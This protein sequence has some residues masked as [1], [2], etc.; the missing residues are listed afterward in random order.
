MRIYKEKTFADISKE[1]AIKAFKERISKTPFDISNTF[2][3][4]SK[5]TSKPVF[6]SCALCNHPTDIFPANHDPK[7]VKPKQLCIECEGIER[8]GY[9]VDISDMIK[10]V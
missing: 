7:I 5:H 10:E 1:K 6:Y 2:S 3:Y 4:L 9:I 8:K